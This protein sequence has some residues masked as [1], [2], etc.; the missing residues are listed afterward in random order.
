MSGLDRF[1]QA[2]APVYEQV[3]EELRAAAKAT[4]WMWF[5]FPQLRGLGS[6]AMAQRYGIADLPEAVAYLR[7]PLLGPR[8]L[9]CTGLLLQAPV[10]LGATNILG[11]VDALKLRSCLT[12]FRL[13][14]RAEPFDAAL[15]RFFGGEADLRTI[16]LLRDA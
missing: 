4:H 12:L 3:L 1:T 14:S 10:S 15:T 7:H 5:I 13:A 6:S 9:E 11:A 2:Q 16:R 8:L